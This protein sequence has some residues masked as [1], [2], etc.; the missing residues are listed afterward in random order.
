M[1]GASAKGI[2]V[3]I[4]ANTQLMEI[5][6]TSG[7]AQRAAAIANKVIQQLEMQIN[8]CIG[9]ESRT[10]SGPFP[11]LVADSDILLTRYCLLEVKHG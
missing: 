5:F 10:C 1:S 4:V 3:R 7:D 6:A 11:Q 8:E 9:E 2:D